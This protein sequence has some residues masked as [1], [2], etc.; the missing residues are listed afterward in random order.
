MMD[1]TESEVTLFPFVDDHRLKGHDAFA[2]SLQLLIDILS[3]LLLCHKRVSFSFRNYKNE[4]A[5]GVDAMEI[6]RLDVNGLSSEM[7]ER[8]DGRDGGVGD[9][10]LT[11]RI[12][13]LEAAIKGEYRDN[14]DIC[15]ARWSDLAV[16]LDRLFLVCYFFALTISLGVLFPRPEEGQYS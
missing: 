1:G 13:R 10:L 14:T 4:R 12:R 5:S 3:R 7:R 8:D 16:V 9:S 6:G 2:L 11:E 15:K